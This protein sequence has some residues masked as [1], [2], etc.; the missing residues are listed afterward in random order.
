MK[1]PK[2]PIII[3]RVIEKN[4]D[5]GKDIFLKKLNLI[6]PVVTF[7]YTV[8]I[9][10]ILGVKK[11]FYLM[12]G[13]D[14]VY[15]TIFSLETIVFFFFIV[16]SI[17]AYVCSYFISISIMRQKKITYESPWVTIILVVASVIVVC[18]LWI[19]ISGVEAFFEQ[20]LL[21]RNTKIAMI[22]ICIS[23]S[24]FY[25]VDVLASITGRKIKLPVKIGFLA[26]LVV[27]SVALIKYSYNIEKDRTSFCTYTN[28]TIETF[29][30]FERLYEGDSTYLFHEAI[31]I[32]DDLIIYKDKK[33]ILDMKGKYFDEIEVER[34]IYK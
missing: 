6:I 14:S 33:I 22:G 24:V 29:V 32:G 4:I 5:V 3:E 18:F 9:G 15:I 28:E 26:L 16:L 2:R 17:I 34:A 31:L 21:E 11:F 27:C 20:R 25:I 7:Y 8:I 23:F 1:V 12:H 13:I 30:T 10:L 19:L